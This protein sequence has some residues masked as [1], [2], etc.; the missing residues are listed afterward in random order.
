MISVLLPVRDASATLGAAIDSL[1]SQT[2]RPSSVIVV[3]DGSTDATPAV[4]AGWEKRWPAVRSIRIAGSGVA[5]ALN[6]ALDAADTPWIARMDADDI[7]H[8]RRFEVQLAHGGS[9]SLVGCEVDHANGAEFDGMRR[10]IEWA[11]GL[12]SHAELELG[13]WI[14]SPLP[15]PGW[16]ARREA[17]EAVGRYDESGEVPE[18]YDWLHRFFSLGFRAVKPGGI[19]LLTWTESPSRLTRTHPAY[20]E[21]AFNRVKA[22]HLPAHVPAGR[23]RY[24]FGLGP[25]A[26]NLFPLLTESLGPFRAIVDAHPGRVGGTYRNVGVWGLARWGEE[27]KAAASRPFVLI[28]VGTTESRAEC[29]KECGDVGLVEREDFLAL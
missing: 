26:K 4:I 15:H 1:F 9:A 19:S 28:G 5:R 22:R 16:C 17:F 2:L 14:D 13:L 18:D 6:V 10:H 23:D 20:T 8:P 25:K 11:N 12:H 21:L 29:A 27:V 7:S 3:D 24:L